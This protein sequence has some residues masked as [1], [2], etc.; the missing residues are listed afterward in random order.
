L[1]HQLYILPERHRLSR[2]AFDGDRLDE[3]PWLPNLEVL[4]SGVYPTG[5]PLTSEGSAHVVVFAVDGEITPSPYG[6]RKGSLIDLHKP[7]IRIDGLGNSRQRRKRWTGHPR[8]LVPTGAR[9]G[10]VAGH[11]NGLGTPR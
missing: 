2:Q 1:L 3:P 10:S 5:D 9:E 11:C 4:L 7:V 6:P 8:R